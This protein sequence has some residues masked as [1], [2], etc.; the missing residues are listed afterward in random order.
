MRPA[1]AAKFRSFLALAAALVLVALNPARAEASIDQAQ[2]A[3]IFQQADT[4]CKRDAGAMWGHTLCGPMLL[5]DPD[6]RS[7]VAN[8]ADANGVLKPSGAVFIGVLPVSEPISDTTMTWSGTRWCELL[9]PW[10]MREDPDMRHVTLA[11]ELFH[12]I[13]EDDLHIQKLDGDNSQLDTLDGRYLLQVEWRALAVALQA[14]TLAGRRTAIADTILFRRERYRRFPAAAANEAALEANEGISEYTGVRLGLLTSEERTR[15][16]LRDLSAFV[17]VP[18]FVRTFA[19]ATGPAYGLL[20]DQADPGWLHNFA[21]NPPGERFDQRL[22]SALHLPPPD[23]AQLYAREAIYDPDG[24]LRAHEVAYERTKRAQLAEFQAKLVDGPI[25]ALPLMDYNM[26]F[27][28][29]SLVPLGDLGTVYPTLTL[30]DAWGTLN[31]ESGGAL[32]RKQPKIATVSATG[33]NAATLRGTGF[34][35]AL[36]PGWIIQPGPRKGDLAVKHTGAAVP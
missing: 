9:W 32:L 3:S 33:F 26:Q 29:Q 5:V 36:N 20:L 7:V 8:Q 21:A 12:R 14:A 27:K 6:D 35:L 16:A 4:I 28:P 10:P 24:S 30:E 22:S 19:Y 34:T 25:L 13:E 17:Q 15:Y 2:A 31:V 1:F 18:S 11:H 23:F